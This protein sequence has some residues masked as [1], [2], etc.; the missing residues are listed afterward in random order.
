[1]SAARI[2]RTRLRLTVGDLQPGEHAWIQAYDLMVRPDGRAY[3][4]HDAT[5]TRGVGRGDWPR[6]NEVGAYRVDVTDDG[7]VLNI[8]TDDLITSDAWNL[9][10]EQERALIPVRKIVL[11]TPED[12][13]CPQCKGT[14]WV[15]SNAPTQ[16]G[17][18]EV[19]EHLQNLLDKL[20]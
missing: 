9:S 13:P 1:M 5:L 7:H 15:R 14:G 2:P 3:L 8:F 4:K 19:R 18:L 10:I 17:T 12:T 20:A 16:I 6:H 11:L